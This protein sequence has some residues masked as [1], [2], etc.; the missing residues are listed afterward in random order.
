[1]PGDDA[2]AAKPVGTMSEYP[3]NATRRPPTANIAGRRAAPTGPTPS[4]PMPPRAPR[5]TGLSR[6]GRAPGGRPGSETRPPGPAVV[7]PIR[8]PSE[9]SD[10]VR[11]LVGPP[12]TK[13]APGASHAGI[14]VA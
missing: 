4:A 10:T 13:R 2:P 8:A 9:S 5:G 6:G 1:M 3:R 12:T 11:G 14:G 7:E